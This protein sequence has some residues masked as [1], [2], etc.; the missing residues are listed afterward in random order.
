MQTDIGVRVCA[1]LGAVIFSTT[2]FASSVYE[3]ARFD[4]RTDKRDLDV[5][6]LTYGEEARVDVS[7]NGRAQVSMLESGQRV[8]L[9]DHVNAIYV[10]IGSG[11][12]KPRVPLAA[13]RLSTTRNL[14]V[15]GSYCRAVE[16]RWSDDV[17]Q[18]QC[19]S[20]VDAAD[21]R[22]LRGSHVGEFMRLVAATG[23]PRA[24]F[25]RAAHLLVRHAEES[26]MPLVIRHFEAGEMLGELR[27]L[28]VTER[29][30]PT[31][32]FDLPRGLK[33]LSTDTVAIRQAAR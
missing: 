25:D 10:V 15:M 5:K 32:V 6:V 28:K 20:Q 21:R 7:T 33:R 29:L 18:E 19:S 27:V 1:V 14:F 22:L 13:T 30:L 4:G 2:A 11:K 31:K 26:T 16:F 9:I 8:I 12:N 23:D 24:L 17:Y 3:A